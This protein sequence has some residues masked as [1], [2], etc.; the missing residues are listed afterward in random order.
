MTGFANETGLREALAAHNVMFTN[1]EGP[2]GFVTVLL[3]EAQARGVPAAAVY[4][5]APNYIQGV[6]NPRVS[7]ALLRTFSDIIGVPLAVERARTRRAGADAP[8]RSTAARSAAVARAG[9]AHAE[10]D[11]RD[12]SRSPAGRRRARA[13]RRV[14]ERARPSSLP[15]PQAVVSEL[16]EFLKQLRR[17]TR[18]TDGGNERSVSAV[19]PAAASASPRARRAPLAAGAFG[20]LLRRPLPAAGRRGAAEGSERRPSRSCAIAGASRTSARASR[21]TRTSVRGSATPRIVCGRWS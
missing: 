17:R 21:S 9:R 6:P 5:F 13:E 19:R 3:A 20:Y 10:P 11:E 8:G 4:A 1:Y 7:H 14:G 2:T 18:T 12:R 16:E 15:S